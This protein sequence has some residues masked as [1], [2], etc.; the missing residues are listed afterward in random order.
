M[1]N[2]SRTKQLLQGRFRILIN[3]FSDNFSTNQWGNG[4]C[5]A[6]SHRIDVKPGS[7]P[8]KLPNRRMPV[9]Y[10]VSLKVKPDTSFMKD[11]I[12]PCH[13]PCSAPK[14]LDPKKD[15]KLRAVIE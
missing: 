12:T 5:D 7:Q 11:L 8:T 13:S 3:D 14:V 9:H 2:R 1:S 6:T 15:E 4:K 10:E